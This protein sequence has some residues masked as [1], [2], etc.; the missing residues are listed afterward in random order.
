MRTIRTRSASSQ[1]PDVRPSDYSVRK[2]CD[3][4]D[5]HDSSV[6]DATGF[7]AAAPPR[8]CFWKAFPW[9]G[10]AIEVVRVMWG[11]HRCWVALQKA[12]RASEEDTALADGVVLFRDAHTAGSEL[13]AVVFVDWLNFVA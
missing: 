6:D 4:E 9:Y 2:K 12:P 5:T 8:G 11:V 3:G 7:Y 10:T 1:Q 13:F